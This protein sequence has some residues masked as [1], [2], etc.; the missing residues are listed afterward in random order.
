MEWEPCLE[1]KHEWEK[2]HSDR[3]FRCKVCK[4]QGYGRPSYGIIVRVIP[5]KCPICGHDTVKEGVACPCCLMKVL[6]EK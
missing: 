5:Y 1:G 4:V 6:E 3:V 2:Y